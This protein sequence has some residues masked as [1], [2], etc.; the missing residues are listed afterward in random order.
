ML[1]NVLIFFAGTLHTQNGQHCME[2]S[3]L[4]QK[5]PAFEDYHLTTVVYAY[6]PLNTHTVTSKE[7]FLNFKQ[8]LHT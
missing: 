5:Q 4:V 7:T 2:E 1:V 6:N 3:E 8:L